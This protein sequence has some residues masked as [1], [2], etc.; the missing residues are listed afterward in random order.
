M[1]LWPGILRVVSLGGAILVSVSLPAPARGQTTNLVATGSRSSSDSP[2]GASGVLTLTGNGNYLK[3]PAELFQGLNVA[4]LECWVKWHTFTGNQ[5]VFEFDAAKRVK[6][7]NRAG[8][9]DLDFWAAVPETP[10]PTNTQPAIAPAGFANASPFDFE[11]QEAAASNPEKSDSS[12]EQ[13]SLT[14]NHW[15]HLAVVFDANQTRLYLDG[16]LAGAARYT[17]GLAGTSGAAR[18]FIGSCS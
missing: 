6:V 16:A 2:L 3:L 7:G 13:G 12:T 8:Q 14:L 4:T 11:K 10:T 1:N 9:P 17:L 18:H 5:H 15:H